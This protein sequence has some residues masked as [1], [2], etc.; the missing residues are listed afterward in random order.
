M[1]VKPIPWKPVYAIF[2]FISFRSV[3]HCIFNSFQICVNVYGFQHDRNI[4][5]KTQ[6]RRKSRRLPAGYIS[7]RIE[8]NKQI[9]IFTCTHKR[10]IRIESIS[11]PFFG[12]TVCFHSEFAEESCVGRRVIFVYTCT[13][14]IS[15]RGYYGAMFRSNLFSLTRTLYAS[16]LI[17]FLFF[18]VFLFFS[19]LSL[20]VW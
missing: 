13:C 6:N 7:F 16:H 1:E 8:E 9:A 4:A 20:I 12:H 5:R 15:V 14:S 17:A 10:N 2:F 19:L 18:F 3:S 11:V